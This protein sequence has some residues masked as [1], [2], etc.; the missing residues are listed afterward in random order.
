M[1][2]GNGTLES[3]A[4]FLQTKAAK[5]SKYPY[6]NLREGDRLRLVVEGGA[7]FSQPASREKGGKLLEWEEYLFEIQRGRATFRVFLSPG[8][9]VSCPFRAL[10]HSSAE[11][12]LVSQRAGNNVVFNPDGTLRSG[13]AI[14]ASLTLGVVVD[15]AFV[16]DDETKPKHSA[17]RLLNL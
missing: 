11:E 13:E 8:I 17:Y 9:F 10:G 12:E 1:A 3:L 5:L 2:K 4:A 7:P 14:V 15:K 16:S 6:F